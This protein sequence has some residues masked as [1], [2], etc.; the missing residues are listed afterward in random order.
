[1]TATHT[2]Q[3]DWK[4]LNQASVNVSEGLTANVNTYALAYGATWA[5]AAQNPAK[6]PASAR[7]KFGLEANL[8]RLQFL[9]ADSDNDKGNAKIWG[10]DASGAPMILMVLTLIQAGT[11]ICTTHPVTGAALTN[12]RYADAITI[13]PNQCGA[14]VRGTNETDGI[15]EVEFD[16]RGRSYAFCD[17]DMNA[18]ATAGTDGICLYKTL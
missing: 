2:D 6:K 10:W 13:N 17:W 5:T 1:M 9:I 18:V 8:M 4:V 16:L 15:V 12:F 3:T 14:I 7:G 11:A